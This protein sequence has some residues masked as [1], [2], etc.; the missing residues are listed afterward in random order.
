MDD[1]TECLLRGL[2]AM[3]A[4]QDRADRARSVRLNRLV[5]QGRQL[6]AAAE[7]K[8]GDLDV[9]QEQMMARGPQAR[10]FF[11]WTG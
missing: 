7:A 2:T 6:R 3:H 11:L 1:L 10:M 5:K 9:L 8:Y 4:E